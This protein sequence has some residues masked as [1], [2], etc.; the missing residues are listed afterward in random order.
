[1]LLTGTLIG[2]EVHKSGTPS[3]C[4]EELRSHAKATPLAHHARNYTRELIAASRAPITVAF[5]SNRKQVIGQHRRTIAAL[6]CN[7]NTETPA[8]ASVTMKNVVPLGE[9]LHCRH[10]SKLSPRAKHKLLATYITRTA[11]V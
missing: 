5:R 11:Q 7:G 8:E 3:T 9:C 6:P 10:A 1:V 2:P 4:G